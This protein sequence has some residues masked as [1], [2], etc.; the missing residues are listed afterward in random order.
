VAIHNRK[1]LLLLRRICRVWDRRWYECCEVCVCVWCV[2][3]C[4]WCACVMSSLLRRAAEELHEYSRDLEHEIL[5]VKRR[6]P[7]PSPER[8]VVVVRGRLER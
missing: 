8:R 2:C 7:L 6:T 4:V 1:I 5:V 3:M